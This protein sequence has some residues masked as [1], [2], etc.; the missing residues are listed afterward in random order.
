MGELLAIEGINSA[1]KTTQ[2]RQV[3]HILKQKGFTVATFKFPDFK[4]PVG[5]LISR[6]LNNESEIPPLALFALFPVN[7]YEREAEVRDAIA[8]SDFVISDRYSES[9]Y[10]YAVEG[11]LPYEWTRIAESLMPS[12]SRVIVLDIDPKVAL[13]RGK[14]EFDLF[15]KDMEF[16]NRVRKRYLEFI[17]QPPQTDQKWILIDATHSV[18][19]VTQK[20]LQTLEISL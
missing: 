11:G 8:N 6:A 13:Q 10:T 15:E 3:S 7:R 2:V 12:A 19:I 1:G 9:E 16:L 17:S 18:D 4:T 20:I 14:E 5:T